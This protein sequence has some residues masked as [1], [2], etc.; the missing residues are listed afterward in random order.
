MNEQPKRKVLLIFGGR[1]QEHQISCA[2]AGGVLRALDQDKWDVYAVGITPDGQ[3]VP[4]PLTPETYD[5]ESDHGYTI[6]AGSKRVAILTGTREIVEY[7]VGEAG[8]ARPDS[9]TPRGSVDIALPLLHGPYGEDGTI[10]GLFEISD[11]P[12]VG[13]GVNASAVCMD[14]ELTKTIVQAAGIPCGKWVAF[15]KREWDRDQAELMR[16][17]EAELQLPLFVKPCRQGSSLGITKVDDYADL[18]SAVQVA[19]EF[20]SRVIVEQGVRGREV[21]C[22]V[23]ERADGTLLASQIGEIAVKGADFYDYKAKYFDPDAV[24]LSCPA[25]IPE[26][27]ADRMR[28]LALRAFAALECE[29]LAR[30]DFFYTEE[31]GELT[32]NEVNTLPGFTPY[33]MYPSA[34]AQ[35]G[36]SYPELL[37][38]LLE[39]ALSRK[40]GL[41]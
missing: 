37:D 8:E 25:D 33:S 35:S 11:L 9:L 4:M 29:G 28:A 38:A 21:E 32:L 36:V 18:E 7:E 31:T 24:V 16:R 5:L 40:A 1:S 26:E 39:Q 10:Q 27:A 15:S 30:L 12:Y 2:T 3:W 14:K 17:I 19:H 34:L 20:D 22:G 41:R 23:L 6:Q 13:C